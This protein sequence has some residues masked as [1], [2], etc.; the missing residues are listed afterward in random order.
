[1]LDPVPTGIAVCSTVALF[2]SS[3]SNRTCGTISP[4]VAS[5]TTSYE[6]RGSCPRR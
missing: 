6:E 2:E 1:M 4:E 3:R 5:I